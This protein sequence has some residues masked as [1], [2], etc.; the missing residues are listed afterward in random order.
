MLKAAG[1]L[2]ISPFHLHQ[3]RAKN[4]RDLGKD[5]AL[6]SRAMRDRYSVHTFT[7]KLQPTVRAIDE[8]NEW[9][10]VFCAGHPGDQAGL[11]RQGGVPNGFIGSGA[12]PPR[13]ICS[14][15]TEIRVV[16]FQRP[17]SLTDP[18]SQSRHSV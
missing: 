18:E 6:L 16:Q 2:P 14:A 7:R 17:S 3:H 13:L 15:P 8:H 4:S 10:A 9:H 5:G 1:S 12:M 11:L